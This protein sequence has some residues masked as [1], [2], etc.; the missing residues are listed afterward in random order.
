MRGQRETIGLQFPVTKADRGLSMGKDFRGQDLRGRSF[1]GE[2]LSY[3]DFS[4]ARLG[5]NDFTGATLTGAKFC[6]ARFGLSRKMWV[7]GLVLHLMGGVLAGMTA[8]FSMLFLVAV[9]QSNLIYLGIHNVYVTGTTISLILFAGFIGWLGIQRNRFDYLLWIILSIVAM[10]GT[11]SVTTFRGSTF[12]IAGGVVAAIAALLAIVIAAAVS[13]ATAAVAA[14][15]TTV[16]GAT[17]ISKTILIVGVVSSLEAM[18][19][20]AFFLTYGFY[21]GFRATRHEEPQ[22]SLL[23]RAR[24]AIG[25]F[26][27][28]RFNGILTEVDFTDADVKHVNFSAAQLIDCTFHGTKNL[29]LAQTK[30]TLLA[31]RKVRELLTSGRSDDH[32]FA[33]LNLSGANFACMDL[34]GFDFSRA[35]LSH[36]DFSGCNLSSAN[37][38]AVTAITAKFNR[39]TLTD[40]NIQNWNI[41][42]RT[43]LAEIICTRVFLGPKQTD[44]NPPQGEFLPGE[45][46]KLYQQVADTVDFILHSPAELAAFIKAVDKLK[47]HGGEAIY[48]QNIERKEESIVVKL[49]APDGFDRDQIYHDVRQEFAVQLAQLETAKTYLTA[50]RDKLEAK[51]GKSQDVLNALLEKMMDRPSNVIHT[52]ENNMTVK[53]QSIGNISNRD[54]VINLGDGAKINNKITLAAPEQAQLTALLEQLAQL[55]QASSLPQDD[56]TY[57]LKQVDTMR[58]E[59][60]QSSEP[61]PGKIQRALNVVQGI[62]GNL[63]GLTETGSKIGEVAGRIGEVLGF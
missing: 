5:S 40:A 16:V 54:G 35:N 11:E 42:A 15:V 47:K 53:R 18:T 14:T 37:L 23:R 55:L 49:K 63:E 24:L 52:L 34:H 10:A 8:V 56:R 62:V 36:A 13:I 61:E 50:E 30:N 17:A 19:I 60:A 59:V 9:V 51:L 25:S 27:A 45:F 48:V 2:D 32:N 43:E 39:A 3:A 29:H 20:S 21:A 41:D 57:A 6:R 58:A 26:G 12:T 1:R 4:D 33:N 22:L 7:G 31:P 28:S 38:S 46:S 44:P